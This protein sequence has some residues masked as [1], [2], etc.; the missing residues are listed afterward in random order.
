LN[1]A[2]GQIP[3]TV[4]FAWNTP[5]RDAKD[6]NR[7]NALRSD[8]AGRRNVAGMKAEYQNEA[9]APGNGLDKIH[10]GAMPHRK[11]D[12]YRPQKFNLSIYPIHLSK[13]FL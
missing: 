11:G 2:A 8:K 5:G 1:T 4:T 12:Y 9:K 6:S 3:G 13:L 10:R 7:K